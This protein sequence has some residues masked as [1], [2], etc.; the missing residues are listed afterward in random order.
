M[1]RSSKL[2]AF[3]LFLNIST[4]NAQGITPIGGGGGGGSG[5]VTSIATAC[6]VAGGTITTTGTIRGA[7][8]DSPVAGTSYTILDGDC[9]LIK[10]S[11]AAGLTTI[12]AGSPAGFTNPTTWFTT[13]KSDGAAGVTLTPSGVTIDGSGSSITIATGKS[14][15]LY[16]DGTNYHTLPG[17][18]VGTG[19]VTTTGSPANGNLAAF[20]GATSVT[21]GNLSGDCTTN[22]TLAA[23]CN[24]PSAIYVS[25][26]WYIAGGDLINTG[27]SNA[28]VNNGTVS[29]Y[30][31]YF[32]GTATISALGGFVNTTSA[33]GNYSVA[34]YANNPATMRPTGTTLGS[35]GNLSTTSS[36]AVNGSV[37]IAISS[38]RWLWA[39]QNSDNGTATLRGGTFLSM[40]GYMGS[41][42]QANIDA[43]TNKLSGVTTSLAFASG[44]TDLT[45]AV[46]TEIQSRTWP[47]VQFKI[48]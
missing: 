41:A 2:L 13:I 30:P 43:G 21:N 17:N 15:D 8:S 45:G 25:N 42:T 26:N 38:P 47:L 37:T 16:S 22:G 27:A 31:F 4:A 28:N 3:L 18:S 23:T 10:R 40:S 48:Q 34:I 14:L 20:S 32:R 33:A 11:T 29:C 46:W 39:C 35:S 36:A 19:T 5:T 7:A 24:S 6:G 1:Q 44:W 9:G 12:T